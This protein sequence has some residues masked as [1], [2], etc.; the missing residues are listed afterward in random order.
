MFR[1]L[2]SHEEA[3]RP[4]LSRSSSTPA[5][6]STRRP[7]HN[8]SVPSTAVSRTVIIRSFTPKGSPKNAD[9]VLDS[10]RVKISRDLREFNNAPALIRAN[11]GFIL[12]L[13]K[14]HPHVF[15][16]A[17]NGL[18]ADGELILDIL[19][20]RKDGWRDLEYACPEALAN[21]ELFLRI[22]RCLDRHAWRAMMFAPP[23]I[24]ADRK[25]VLEAV[26]RSGSSSLEF[27]AAGVRSDKELIFESLNFGLDTIWNAEEDFRKEN[28]MRVGSDLERWAPWH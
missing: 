22:I 27:A 6:R 15:Q 28:T 8:E 4:Q 16:F 7:H 23:V 3:R 19:R 26:R 2:T 5:G 13:A 21:R 24:C 10:W 18:R 1:P 9:L 25:L 17:S 11:R 14:V 20:S 12:D